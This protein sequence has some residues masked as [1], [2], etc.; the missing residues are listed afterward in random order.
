M[1]AASLE[2]PSSL[3]GLTPDW[4]NWAFREGGACFPEVKHVRAS[5]ISEGKGF[6]TAMARVDL[7]YATPSGSAPK[8]IIAKM[9]S[10]DPTAR[11][12]CAAMGIW[13]RECGFYAQLAPRITSRVPRT[14]FIGADP[15]SGAYVLLL[16]DL[17]AMTAG[18]QIRGISL[19]DANRVIDWLAGFHASC[20]APEIAD[21]LGWLPTLDQF[22]AGMQPQL[23]G[24]LPRFL[25]MFGDVVSSSRA[26]LLSRM[27]PRFSRS[28][29]LS[30][31][32]RTAVHTDF[33]LDNMFFDRGAEIVVFDWQ[34]LS[35]G[36]G[37]YDVAGFIVGSFSPEQRR[38]HERDLLARYRER[39]LE[40]G[41]DPGSYADLFEEYRGQLLNNIGVS[42]IFSMLDCSTERSMSL[43]RNWC[44][45]LF[46]AAED[47]DI[48]ALVDA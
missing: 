5:A 27:L 30:K 12:I 13:E 6:L 42:P 4:L 10:P 38:A 16:E 21:G 46:S 35:F 1:P 34:S 41:V 28:L 7:D 31:M 19:G 33:R 36:Q 20:A 44:D 48:G 40:H 14:Y 25:E 18:D 23:L 11:A 2:F 9:Q 45:R 32:Q 8:S 26:A 43:F 17:G 37:L 24:T 39:L 29:A 3:E 15:A 22:F 47:H